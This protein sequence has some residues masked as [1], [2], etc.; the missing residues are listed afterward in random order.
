MFRS[1]S[2]RRSYHG[3]D[4]LG[5]ESSSPADAADGGVDMHMMKSSSSAGGVGVQMKRTVSVPAGVFDFRFSKKQGTT[6]ELGAKE[7]KKA[8]KIHPLFGLFD[9][10]KRKKKWTARPEISR[11]LEYVKEGGGWNNPAM[12]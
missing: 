12:N 8:S 3:Y 9:G 6:L 7:A 11:Y 1:L 2:T 5:I 10:K 4:R